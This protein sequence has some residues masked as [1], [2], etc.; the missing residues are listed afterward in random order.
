MKHKKSL[1]LMRCL[2]DK[3]S[4]R[5]YQNN[6][7]KYLWLYELI[8]MCRVVE[9]VSNS[10]H[11]A[12]ATPAGGGTLPGC[13]GPCWTSPFYVNL[14]SLSP[15]PCQ[16]LMLNL[17]SSPYHSIALASCSAPGL[18]RHVGRGVENT[19]SPSWVLR[20]PCQSQVP[21]DRSKSHKKSG[22]L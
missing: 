10:D 16:K 1:Y 19:V 15:S 7:F 14:C 21:R 22:V 13:R 17:D 6:K 4:L 5:I 9:Q 18:Q 2:C 11:K 12:L 8:G 20:R 3:L